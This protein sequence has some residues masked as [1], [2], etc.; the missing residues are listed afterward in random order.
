MNHDLTIIFCRY[1]ETSIA[2]QSVTTFFSFNRPTCF[3]FNRHDEYNDD[4]D[5]DHRYQDHRHDQDHHHDHDHPDHDHNDRDDDDHNI[6]ETFKTSSKHFHNIFKTSCNLQNILKPSKHVQDILK[7]S[8]THLLRNRILLPRC[9]PC[10]MLKLSKHTFRDNCVWEAFLDVSG[11]ITHQV[12]SI[13]KHTCRDNCFLEVSGSINSNH[14]VST[15]PTYR[16]TDLLTYLPSYLRWGLMMTTMTMMTMTTTT[17]T[18]T[19]SMMTTTTTMI[20]D[21]CYLEASGNINWNQSYRHHVI[22]M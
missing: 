8:S 22:H 3:S 1:L 17:I 19:T 15:H 20:R 10:W 5:H 18:T 11:N 2:I 21:N 4:N 6:V 13:R 12:K 14:S 9:V 7:T 16:P